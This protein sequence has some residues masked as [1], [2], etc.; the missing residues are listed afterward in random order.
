[1]TEEQNK[2]WLLLS[3][4]GD[5]MYYGDT[6]LQCVAKEQGDRL[7][8]ARRLANI[9]TVMEENSRETALQ[10]RMIEHWRMGQ[11]ADDFDVPLA[12]PIRQ[13]IRQLCELWEK[14]LGLKDLPVGDSDGS[15]SLL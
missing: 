9:L 12:K 14:D 13:Q 11:F 4:S 10:Q 15:G 6:P 5:K 3:P 1:M 8:P 7:T 2:Q